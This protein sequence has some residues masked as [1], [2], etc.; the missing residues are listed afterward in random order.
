M[1]TISWEQDYII[2]K[3]TWFAKLPNE[4]LN[5]HEYNVVMSVENHVIVIVFI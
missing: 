1:L 2:F 3:V 5:M 4:Y